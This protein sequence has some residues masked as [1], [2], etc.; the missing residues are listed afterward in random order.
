MDLNFY[1]S[2]KDE[3][4]SCENDEA[5]DEYYGDYLSI[6]DQS[7]IQKIWMPDV[8]IVNA[9]D[10]RDHNLKHLRLSRKGEILLSIRFVFSFANQ[11][12]SH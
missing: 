9:K 6:S 2:W 1:F 12:Y 10:I 3:R 7:L 4:L 11:P 5:A 8:F